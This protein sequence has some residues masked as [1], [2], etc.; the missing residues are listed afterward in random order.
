MDVKARQYKRLSTKNWCLWTL[1]LEK[2]LE[3]PLD[4]K[5]IKLVN[6]KENQPWVSI[7]RTDGKAEAPIFWPPYAKTQLIRKDPEA[8]RDWRQEKGTTGDE[9]VG[10]HH[11]FN[12]HE[13]EQ[14]PGDGEGRGSPAFCRPCCKESDN[15]AT[16]QQQINQHKPTLIEFIL[17]KLKLKL[18][19]R[20]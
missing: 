7:G 17:F 3:S 14:T 10:W 8:G 12:G 18:A 13:F 16:E 20:V 15:W 9:M 1:V 5:E 2:T 4:C 19:P 6:P 11:Q